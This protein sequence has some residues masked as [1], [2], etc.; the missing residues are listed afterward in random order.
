LLDGAGPAGRPADRPNKS[1]NKTRSSPLSGRP[2]ETRRQPRVAVFVL[3]SFVR[4]HF[5]CGHIQAD[6][7]GR[8]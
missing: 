7:G 1:K 5:K 2:A 4:S 3:I 6:T 8:Q